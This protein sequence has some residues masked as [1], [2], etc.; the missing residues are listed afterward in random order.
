M[1]VRS[2]VNGYC[3]MEQLPPIFVTVEEAKRLL[4]I[5][6]TRIYELMNA[7]SIEK[8]KSG[9]RTL[10]PYKSLTDYA[11]SLTKETA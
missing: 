8:V 9:S 1:G 10:I 11:A 2:N 4:R 7:G 6:H 5:G 3:R